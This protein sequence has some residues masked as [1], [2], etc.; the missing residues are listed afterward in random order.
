MIRINPFSHYPSNLVRRI[1]LPDSLPIRSTLTRRT[2]VS[3]MTMNRR[4]AINASSASAVTLNVH[5]KT[6][7]G[8]GDGGGVVEVRGGVGAV[9]TL[10]SLAVICW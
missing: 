5:G 9:D 4:V 3:M 2:S 8:L 10:P 6:G 1:S 7:V